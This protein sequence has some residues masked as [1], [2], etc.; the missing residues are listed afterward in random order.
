LAT[1]DLSPEV[2]KFLVQKRF[3]NTAKMVPSDILSTARQ[4]F[5]SH[6]I[7]VTNIVAGITVRRTGARCTQTVP[8][9]NSIISGPRWTRNLPRCVSSPPCVFAFTLTDTYTGLS[10]Q[11]EG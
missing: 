8:R 3:Q 11:R 7:R 4:V 1:P 2:K 10:G 9:G 6:Y 5:Y